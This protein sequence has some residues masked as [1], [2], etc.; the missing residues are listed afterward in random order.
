MRWDASFA[1]VPPELN[2]GA[3]EP[4]LGP[5]SLEASSTVGAKMPRVLAITDTKGQKQHLGL[6]KNEKKQK[7]MLFGKK[8]HYF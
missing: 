4:R 1:K 6:K 8:K 3:R 5:A 7:K 2:K